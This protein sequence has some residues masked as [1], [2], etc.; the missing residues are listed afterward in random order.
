MRACAARAAKQ[1]FTT[2][3]ERQVEAHLAAIRTE[4][5]RCFGQESRALQQR[6]EELYQDTNFYLA[7]RDALLRNFQ[8]EIASLYDEMTANKAALQELFEDK[9]AAYADLAEAQDDLEHWYSKSQSTFFFGNGGRELPGDS[10]FGQSL[11][12]RDSYK[13]ERDD[14]GERIAECREAIG[15]LKGR[16]Q[17]IYKEIQRV[18][19]ERQRMFDL[20]HEGY[21]RSR[22]ER[23][24][25][26]LQRARAQIETRLRDLDEQRE[27][28]RRS[29]MDQR[30]VQALEQRIAEL[31]QDRAAFIAA[32]NGASAVAARQQAHRAEWLKRHG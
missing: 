6:L 9:D 20:K 21:T 17:E 12:D 30:G 13:S 32:F 29:E 15:E 31:Q 26:A 25:I 5:E 14:A 22:V 16:N 4:E 24:L 1:F 8:A 19:G 10:L 18:K 28:L 7:Q 27:E 2:D 11:G 23:G 3:L